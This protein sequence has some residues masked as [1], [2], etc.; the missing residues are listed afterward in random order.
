[1]RELGIGIS[2]AA[3]GT[4]GARSGNEFLINSVVHALAQITGSHIP[5]DQCFVGTDRLRAT[6]RAGEGRSRCGVAHGRGDRFGYG[7]G[8]AASA[9]TCG[10]SAANNESNRA[11]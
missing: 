1:M 9:G 6:G 10:E 8:I 7:G 11:R 5:V 3:S 4:G 2:D